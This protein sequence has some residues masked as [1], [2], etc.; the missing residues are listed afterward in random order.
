MSVLRFS[1][2]R[3]ILGGFLTFV[4]PIGIA[5]SHAQTPLPTP[6]QSTI[7]CT[8]YAPTPTTNSGGEPDYAY[9]PCCKDDSDG[10]PTTGK[11]MVCNAP[12]FACHATNPAN[13]ANFGLICLRLQPSDAFRGNICVQP[14]EGVQFYT[15]RELEPGQVLTLGRCNNPWDDYCVIHGQRVPRVNQAG[16]PEP[17]QDSHYCLSRECANPLEA[18][19]Q[20]PCRCPADTQLCGAAGTPGSDMTCCPTGVNC[21]NGACDLPTPTPIPSRTATPLPDNTQDYCSFLYVQMVRCNPTAVG[22]PAPQPVEQYLTDPR[23]G[24]GGTVGNPPYPTVSYQY[25]EDQYCLWYTRVKANNQV[26]GSPVTCDPDGNSSECTPTT[27][28][29]NLV[30]YSNALNPYRCDCYDPPIQPSDKECLFG[31]RATLDCS[32]PWEVDASGNVIGTFNT[33]LQGGE[34]ECAAASD[35]TGIGWVAI[36]GENCTYAY[37]SKHPSGLNC[38]WSDNCGNYIDADSEIPLA[39]AMGLVSTYPT[40]SVSYEQVQSNCGCGKCVSNWRYSAVCEPTQ[41][42][43]QYQYGSVDKVGPNP[44]AT[45]AAN[46]CALGA[47][48]GWIFAGSTLAADGRRTCTW[49]KYNAPISGS[50]S[51]MGCTNN[52]D[53]GSDATAPG[54]PDNTKIQEE[55]GCEAPTPTPTPS[56]TPTPTPTITP[57]EVPTLTPTPTASPTGT[58]TS[59]PTTEPTATATPT[60]TATPTPTPTLTATPT[61]PPTPP[62]GTPVPPSTPVEDIYLRR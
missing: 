18:K 52:G 34:R 25:V 57:T 28:S 27:C 8:I 61:V 32:Q 26:G 17:C 21:V 46:S 2:L 55:C 14:G 59:T 36:P 41:S 39:D 33:V 3:C 12:G 29:A 30:P 47:E 24:L 62:G 10:N 60:E 1:S 7:D 31:Y 16:N 38:N 45:S 54:A 49:R 50:G 37:Q 11:L 9:D 13:P 20:Y 4:L 19:L 23:C 22:T 40:L 42:G 6:F 51:F 15:T 44:A 43:N 53:C 35:Q 48:S 58:M 5:S 56:E